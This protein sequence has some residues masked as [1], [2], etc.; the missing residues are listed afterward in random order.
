MTNFNL[1]SGFKGVSLKN[2]N[3]KTNDFDL[4]FTI[5]EKVKEYKQKLDDAKERAEKRYDDFTAA[6]NDYQNSEDYKNVQAKL[7]KVVSIFE[8]I[9]T[10]L[11]SSLGGGSGSGGTGGS[12]DGSAAGGGASDALSSI[13][14]TASDLAS[15]A[16]SILPQIM[17]SAGQIAEAI[18]G[19]IENLTSQATES[20]TET[21]TETPTEE[22]ELLDTEPSDITSDEPVVLEK[23]DVPDG[24]TSYKACKKY[25]ELDEGTPESVIARGGTMPEGKYEGVTY[26][27]QTDPETGVR[28]V[29]FDG[30]DTKYY[31]AAMGTYYGEVGDIFKVTTDEGNT[32]NVI[33]CE[34]KGS[35]VESNTSGET[36]YQDK[37]EDGYCVTEFYVD[38]YAEDVKVYRDGE[39]IGTTGN[40]N[41]CSQFSGNIETIERLQ[42]PESVTVNV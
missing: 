6:V 10:A 11:G 32:Y 29:S 9:G 26:N 13:G 42:Y 41:D 1:N 30:D 40:Y 16:S 33:I 39:Y 38:H 12:S 27:T 35:D 17:S 14:Q 28:Y 20:Q 36:M 34:S 18:P 5:Q 2:Y 8:L 22:P 24:N 4:E 7:A 21:G 3:Y 19:L 25:T 31:C 37:G 23:M 15:Q